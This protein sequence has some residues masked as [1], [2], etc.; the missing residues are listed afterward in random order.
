MRFEEFLAEFKSEKESYLAAGLIDDLSVYK[1]VTQALKPLGNNI[2]VLQDAVLDVKGYEARVPDNF[3]SLYAAYQCEPKS[4]Y[5]KEEDKPIL[6][7][8]IQWVE[9]VEQSVKWNSCELCCEEEEEKLITEKVWMNDREVKFYYQRPKLLKLGRGFK[10]SACTEHC[11]NLVVRD[12]PNEIVI[13]GNVVYTNFKEGTIYLQ[14]YGMELDEKGYVIIPEL[15]L[16]EIEQYVTTYVNW[17]F[18]EKLLTNQDEPNVVTLFQYYAQMVERHKI[19][20]I[21]ESKF[22][23]LRP[24][25]IKMLGLKNRALFDRYEK[26]YSFSR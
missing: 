20:A 17:K 18:Y 25:D 23:T 13:N 22:S 6:Q 5:Y 15:G 3:F 11:R 10:R 8:A 21:S 2:M 16:G 19:L 24:E 7:N 9:K 14:Y 1:W 26:G 12:N 4:Y